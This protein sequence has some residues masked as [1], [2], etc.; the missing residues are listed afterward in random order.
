V[1]SA[2]GQTVQR[3]EVAPF[4]EEQVQDKSGFKKVTTP[5]F[6]AQDPPCAAHVKQTTLGD[7]YFQAALAAVADQNPNY[8][9]GMII[10]DPKTETVTVR[11]YQVDKT[12]YKNHKFTPKSIKVEKSIPQNQEG[13]AIYNSGALWVLMVQKAY[14]AGGFTGTGKMPS[15]PKPSY[16]DIE[17]GYSDHAFEVILGQASQIINV[18]GGSRYNTSNTNKDEYYNPRT[19][20]GRDNT[21]REWGN[22]H[23]VSLPWDSNAVQQY[24]QVKKNTPNNYSS[25]TLL[26]QIFKNDTGKVDEWITFVKTGTL[27]T[28]FKTQANDINAGLSTSIN[29]KDI[30]QLFNGKG[31]KD[32]MLKWLQDQKLFPGDLG[33][34]IYSQLQLKNFND[35][36]DALASKKPVAVNT[37]QKIVKSGGGSGASGGEDVYGGLAGGHAYTALGTKITKTNNPNDQIP[38]NFYWIKV[39]NPWGANAYA[40]KNNTKEAALPGFID[41]GDGIFFLELSQFSTYFNSINIGATV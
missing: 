11:L 4:E 20:I 24:D 2:Q 8:I 21:G 17:G 29:L 6:P 19:V 34:A 39:R 35:I 27:T 26:M 5:L 31:F 40:N 37:N 10:D 41:Q 38:G 12:D 3:E 33:K 22:N 30:G 14:A 16:K 13:D 23:I 18:Q 28:L 32:D 1:Q 15:S 36:K 25:L 9:K 7:C